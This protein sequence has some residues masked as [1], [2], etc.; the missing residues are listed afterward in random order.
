MS[1]PQSNPESSPAVAA[2]PAA[3]LTPDQTIIKVLTEC[4]DSLKEGLES[5]GLLEPEWSV[6]DRTLAYRVEQVLEGLEQRRIRCGMEP[7]P[8]SAPSNG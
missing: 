3:E 5:P 4:R 2:P 6:A 7:T 1:D 8:T